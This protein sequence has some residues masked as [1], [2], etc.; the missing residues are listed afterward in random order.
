L[1]LAV[2]ATSLAAAVQA[3]PA[4]AKTG[5][6][7][8]KARG[9][10]SQLRGAGGCVT[11]RSVRN[12]CASARALKGPGPFMGSRAIVLS[13]N[14]KSVYVA[15]SRSD[16]IA[17][18]DRDKQTG[19]LSQP[20]GK[21]GC[22]TARGAGGCATAIG[23]DGPN[24]LAISADGRDV[25]ATSRA[26][27][28]VTAFGR[29]RSTG[30]LHQ[31]PGGCI[32]GIPLPGCAAGQALVAPDVL[33][34][35]RDGANVYA[36]SF[37]GNAVAVF[38]RNAKTGALA[39]PSGTAAC[40]AQATSGCATGI[41]LGSPEGLAISGDGS[42]VYVAS[43]VSNA[44]AVLTRNSSTG[45]LTQA[46]DGTGC[47]VDAAL[48][49]C[50][51][52]RELAGANAVVLS[53]GGTDLYATSLS[54]DSVTSFS[55][56]ASGSLAQKQATAGCLVLL[57]AVGCSFGRA[58]SAP[59]GLAV[60]GD[61]ASVYAAAFGTGAIDVL[62]RKKATGRVFQKPGRAGCLAARRVP[63]CS[64]ARALKGVSSIAVSPDS[65]YVYSTSF[66]SNAVDVFR[67]HR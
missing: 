48:T 56:A 24:S 18:F 47:I 8:V 25:Y 26:S 36:G 11:D 53:P 15:S 52:G 31:L 16:A 14:G 22:I 30:A 35:S 59:E 29:N 57:R 1:G 21:G 33:V 54:S 41:A 27:N 3:A 40:I 13:P 28:S 10:L 12:R 58:I 42:S 43:A 39:Q 38:S 34:V 63:G 51:T 65:R 37:F 23:L 5:S 49:G 2:L 4:A 46:T 60:S 64:P 61:G 6:A 55:R 19:H 67:R 66:G 44:V 32:S 7:A 45:A 9:T 50:T 62:D 17:I 20:G